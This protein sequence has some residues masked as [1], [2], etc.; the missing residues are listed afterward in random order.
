MPEN[1]YMEFGQNESKNVD[2][3]LSTAKCKSTDLDLMYVFMVVEGRSM[4]K[5][6][7]YFVFQEQGK[8]LMTTPRARVRVPKG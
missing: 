7:R 5:K 6:I 2:S 3:N 4:C 1:A 8:L